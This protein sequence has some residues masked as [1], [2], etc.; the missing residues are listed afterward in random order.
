MLRRQVRDCSVPAID[1]R[2]RQKL[3]SRQAAKRA[4]SGSPYAIV[5]GL[6]SR[7]W[8][9]C[10]AWLPP[11]IGSSASPHAQDTAYAQG[12]WM[13]LQRPL[14]HPIPIGCDTASDQRGPK[15]S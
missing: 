10:T 11:H 13:I 8:R 3:H 9:R 7:P 14:S 1:P 6:S 5:P 12:H 15:V 4:R 2:G